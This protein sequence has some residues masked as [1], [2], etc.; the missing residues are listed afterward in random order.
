M[1]FPPD[2]QRRSRAVTRYSI[3]DL[4]TTSVKLNTHALKKKSVRFPTTFLEEMRL[5]AVSPARMPT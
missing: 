3:Q 5:Y 2:G 4:N 1:L